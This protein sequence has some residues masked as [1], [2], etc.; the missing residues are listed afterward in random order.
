M[1]LFSWLILRIAWYAVQLI[2]LPVSFADDGDEYPEDEIPKEPLSQ[3]HEEMKRFSCDQ[4]RT[5]FIMDQKKAAKGVTNSSVQCS[6]PFYGQK[7]C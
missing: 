4:K 7:V 1:K 5:L 2:N 3:V 6:R